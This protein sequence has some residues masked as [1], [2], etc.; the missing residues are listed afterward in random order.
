MKILTLSRNHHTY[1]D[2]D[3]IYAASIGAGKISDVIHSQCEFST[4]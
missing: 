1:I 4:F 3:V 2:G